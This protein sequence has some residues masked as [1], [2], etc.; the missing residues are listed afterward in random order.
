MPT[1][2]ELILDTWS[3][4]NFPILPVKNYKLVKP[5]EMPECGVI[6]A[7]QVGAGGKIQVLMVNIWA[8]TKETKEEDLQKMDYDSLDAMLA[9]GWVGD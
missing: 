4:P 1:E 2:K 7:S 9:A 3:W 5:G 8:L 6:T